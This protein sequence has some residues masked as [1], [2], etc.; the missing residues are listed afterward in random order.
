MDRPW[1]PLWYVLGLVAVIAGFVFTIWR[2]IAVR[3]TARE[4]PGR[5]PDVN[6]S[7]LNWV[8]LLSLLVTALVIVLSLLWRRRRRRMM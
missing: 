4:W 7:T 1:S 5:Y 2:Y 3:I 6:W 8:L